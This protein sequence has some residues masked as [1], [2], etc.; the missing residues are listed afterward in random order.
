MNHENNQEHKE[1]R[2]SQFL[3][4]HWSNL[5]I[6]VFI[7]L[8]IVPQSRL[9]IQVFINQLISFEPDVIESEQQLIEDYH[10]PL[11]AFSGEKVNFSRSK[12]KVIV[13]N[14]W[15]TWCAPCI[16]EMPGLEALYNKYGTRV[17]FYFV[18]SDKKST[19]ENFMQEN[20]YSFPVFAPLQLSPRALAAQALPTT[21]VIDK[22]GTIVMKEFGAADWNSAGVHQVLD[23]LLE[24]RIQ[25]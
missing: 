13:L 4:K 23:R 5:L 12:G 10:W 9:P 3:K 15:A 22:N 1:K 6:L 2:P 11:Q 20:K 14:F 25:K 24:R 18:S 19:I 17:D 8:L 16:A 21:Y 7:I